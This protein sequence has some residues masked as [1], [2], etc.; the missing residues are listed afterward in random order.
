MFGATSI[1]RGTGIASDSSIF[2]CPGSPGS[3]DP[4]FV[5]TALSQTDRDAPIT[6]RQI[7]VN[8]SGTEFTFFRFR[9]IRPVTEDESDTS[10]NPDRAVRLNRV[11]TSSRRTSIDGLPRLWNVFRRARSLVG[12]RPERPHLVDQFTESIRSYCCPGSD[13]ESLRSTISARRCYPH[14]RQ[15]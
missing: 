1:A 8:R 11:R 7:R 3:V 15:Q 9:S 4:D 14:L 5:T 12:P 10:G 13:H 6:F 2:L